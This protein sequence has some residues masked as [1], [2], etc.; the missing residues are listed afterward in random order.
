MATV[1][2]LQEGINN[3]QTK[4]EEA[5]MRILE[6]VAELRRLIDEGIDPDDLDPLISQLDALTENVKSIDP[7]PAFPAENPPQPP[8]EG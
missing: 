6:D 1:E 4:L 3:L 5:K 8:Q 2:Q 7:D